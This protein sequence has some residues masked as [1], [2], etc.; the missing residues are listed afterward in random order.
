MWMFLIKDQIFLNEKPQNIKIFTVQLN[1]D[2]GQ[3][4]NL[5]M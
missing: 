5:E 3:D 2:G 1:K 4:L